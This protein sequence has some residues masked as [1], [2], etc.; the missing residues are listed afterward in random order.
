[1]YMTSHMYFKFRDFKRFYSINNFPKYQHTNIKGIFW[2]RETYVGMLV[3]WEIV[4]HIV[5]I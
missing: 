5:Y 1:M 4:S 3:F 2:G